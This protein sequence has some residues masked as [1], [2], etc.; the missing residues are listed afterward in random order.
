MNKYRPVRVPIAE[1]QRL[2]KM[3]NKA[4]LGMFS[5]ILIKKILQSSIFIDINIPKQT[6]C[7]FES[8]GLSSWPFIL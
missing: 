5:L 6:T 8:R 7:L 4:R 3:E 2:L 1:S